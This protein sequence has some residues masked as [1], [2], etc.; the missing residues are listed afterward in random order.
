[1]ATIMAFDVKIERDAQEYA[2]KNGMKLSFVT[3]HGQ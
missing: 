3:F 2:N 1:M